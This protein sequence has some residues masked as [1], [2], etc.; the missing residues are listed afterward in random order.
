M[1]RILG[2]V[3]GV[4]I[5][6]AGIAAIT[7]H[8]EVT[9]LDVER[10]TDDVSVITGLGGNVGVLKTSE[11]PVIVDT[12]T[13]RM[14]GERIRELAEKIAGGPT[15]AI[16]NTHYHFD[17]SHGNPGFAAHSRIIST[18]RTLDYMHILDADYW[19]KY[20]DFMPTETFTDDHEIVIGGKTIRAIHPGRGHTGGDLVVYFVDDRVIHTG[21]LF[22]N[23]R[24]PNIDLEAGG[25]VRE[26]ADTID[27]ILELDF[28]R[29]I[30][31]HGPVTDRAGLVGFQ[32]FIRELAEVGA[33]AARQGLTLEQT[34]A[35]T[36]LEK[37][38]GYEDFGVP[39]F[40]RLDRDFV[41]R[42]AWEEATGKVTAVD[43]P[44]PAE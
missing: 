38:A 35:R 7:V 18:E 2:I 40:M 13:F 28:D 12:M 1:G 15:Q 26:W 17:H 9:S 20:P 4:V 42:R 30:P 34:L 8:D 25:S 27:R 32:D 37:N 3:A 31:G 5:V 23:K 44:P 39:I 22:F 41:I 24:Y 19:S 11:G 14:Q 10:V 16:F 6:A 36:H 33:E 21:D 43:L 29:V